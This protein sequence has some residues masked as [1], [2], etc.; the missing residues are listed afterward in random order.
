MV[1]PI[2]DLHN[3]PH[4]GRVWYS[5]ETRGAKSFPSY[6]AIPYSLHYILFRYYTRLVDLSS[7]F[8]QP[9]TMAASNTTITLPNPHAPMQFLAP[10]P[11][12]MSLLYAAVGSLAVS[13]IF[14]DIKPFFDC[15]KEQQALIWDILLHIPQDYKIATQFRINFSFII[16]C[17]AR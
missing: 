9:T 11:R 17:I 4:R 14:F 16:Y 15:W 7:S 1:C 13:T 2:F 6:T 8:S 3:L 10:T 5:Y 12:T